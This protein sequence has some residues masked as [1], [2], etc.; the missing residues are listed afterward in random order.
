VADWTEAIRINPQFAQAYY[1]R[2]L[3]RANWADLDGT[4][5]DMSHLLDLMPD[6]PEAQRV[7]DRIEELKRLKGDEQHE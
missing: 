6:S 4:I 1:N 5:E 2:G 3:V 7:R